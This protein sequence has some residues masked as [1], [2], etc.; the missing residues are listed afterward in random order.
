[1]TPYIRNN[2]AGKKGFRICL[3]CKQPYPAVSIGPMKFKPHTDSQECMDKLFKLA[4]QKLVKEGEKLKR[5][6][7]RVWKEKLKTLGDYEKEA[8]REFQ[9]WVRKRDSELPCISCGTLKSTVWD[10]GHFKKAELYSGV[11][12]HELNCWKQCGKCNRYLGGN[13]LNYRA[14]LILRVGEEKVLE[15]ERIAQETRVHKFSKEELIEIRKK[16]FQLNK[17]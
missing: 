13:E 15:L 12:F 4:N 14:A 7:R 9:K 3:Q 8:K 6:E 1:M 10:G 11:I 16:Y 17:A 2:K 5:E